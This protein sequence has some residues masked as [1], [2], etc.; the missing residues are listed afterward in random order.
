MNKVWIYSILGILCI[1]PNNVFASIWLA[2]VVIVMAINSFYHFLVAI[3]VF[4]VIWYL[5]LRKSENVLRITILYIILWFFL[6]LIL[7]PLVGSFLNFKLDLL[8]TKF[9]LARYYLEYDVLSYTLGFIVSYLLVKKV[10]FVKLK[11]I[12]ILLSLIILLLY[13]LN[14]IFK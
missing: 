11:L 13:S 1:L 12:T 6:K 2:N 14:L 7:S 9:D 4:W 3:L 10:T 8:W 5:L